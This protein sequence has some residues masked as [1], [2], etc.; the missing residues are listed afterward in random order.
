VMREQIEPE[1]FYIGCA[2]RFGCA[3]PSRVFGSLASYTTL[4]I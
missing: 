4:M 2:S 1:L 3:E